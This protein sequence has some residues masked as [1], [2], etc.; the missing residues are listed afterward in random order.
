[1]MSK[2]IMAGLLLMAGSGR[3]QTMDPA[4]RIL[5]ENLQERIDG[6]EKRLAE[7]EKGSGTAHAAPPAQPAASAAAAVHQSHDTPPAAVQTEQ[8]AAPS[9]PALKI[10]G[11]ADVNFAASTLKSAATGFS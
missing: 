10:S 6:L 7:L 5:I 11:F 9:Y 3:A 8:T 1:M 2:V 4:T